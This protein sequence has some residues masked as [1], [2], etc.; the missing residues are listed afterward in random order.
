MDLIRD[1]VKSTM[2]LTGAFSIAF[3]FFELLGKETFL[4]RCM[5]EGLIAKTAKCLKC[6]CEMKL[7]EKPGRTNGYECRCR[8]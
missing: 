4:E 2:A 1:N 3:T 7:S 6:G 5:K 8:K